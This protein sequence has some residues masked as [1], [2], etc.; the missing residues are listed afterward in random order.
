[1]CGC[2]VQKTFQGGKTV[3]IKVLRQDLFCVSDKYANVVITSERLVIGVI[4]GEA[5]EVGKTQITEAF[6]VMVRTWN[7]F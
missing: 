4:G 5:V 1:M 6:Y 2:M 3:S 7:L